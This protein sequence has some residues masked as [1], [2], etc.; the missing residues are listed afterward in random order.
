MNIV[1][2]ILFQCRQ[3]PPALAIG[4]PGTSLATISYAR[5]ERFIHNIARRALAVGLQRGNVV[6]LHVQDQIFH[7]ALM[8]G[9]AR[10]GIVTL[11]ISD[12]N[13]PSALRV[14]AVLT[15]AALGGLPRGATALLVDLS[16]TEGDGSPLEA[17][18]LA[19][20]PNGIFR[21]ALT[22]GSTGEARV[23]ALT[24]AMMWRRVAR[25]AHASGRRWLE[26]SR[27]FCD[28]TLRSEFATRMLIDVLG[29]GGSFFFSGA[30][31]M[32]TLQ[33]FDLYKIQGLI[34]SPGG[35][36]NILTFYESNGAFQPSFDI[37]IST[38]SMLHRALSERLRAR[39][40]SYVLVRYAAVETA[41]V[42]SAP[43][44]MLA[45]TAGAV[46]YVVPGVTVQVVDRAGHPVPPD[47]DGLLRIRS[48]TT[49]DGYLGTASP[50]F[51]DGFF[52]PGDIG[53]LSPSG[54]LIITGRE[55]QVMNVG[56]EKVPPETIEEVI[57]ACEGVRQAAVFCVPNELGVE[58]VWALV[59]P[60]AG[61]DS[62]KLRAWCE[63]RLSPVTRPARIA[64]AEA[65]PRNANG[66]IERH[67]L[68]EKFVN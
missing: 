60:D 16:W 52:Q 21:L 12:M 67:R 25:G 23:V 4:A 56:G 28:M 1:D 34:A 7:A 26:C 68:K 22:S 65:L 45:D 31:P 32:D 14:D 20:D 64:T 5:L 41:L 9:L 46:G 18:L 44:H 39:L 2:F 63:Q 15:D 8:F 30:T 27:V 36:S 61:F 24:H 13:I 11:S 57:T 42:A 58:E 37:I 49:I 17:P 19:D 66:K 38:G 10:V 43:A 54:L 33:A 6:A 29:R 35:L 53:R 40:C 3:N 48:A 47:T 51:R 62:Q 59:V 55:S 50:A